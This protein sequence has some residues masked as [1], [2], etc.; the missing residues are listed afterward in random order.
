MSLD[1]EKLHRLK[2]KSFDKLYSDNKAKWKEMVGKALDYAKTCVG[3]G[4]KVRLGDV[5]SV[6]QH[7]IKIDPTFEEHTKKKSLHQKYWVI[8]FAE[9]IVDCVYPQPDLTKPAKK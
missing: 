4:E 3:S 1:T 5:I 9:Y 6:M 8:M 7:A 2:G